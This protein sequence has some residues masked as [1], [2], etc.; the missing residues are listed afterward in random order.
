MIRSITAAEAIAQNRVQRSAEGATATDFIGGRGIVSQDA[1]AFLVYNPPHYVTPAHFH[2]VNQFQVVVQGTARIGTHR[3]LPGSVHYAETGTPY[4]PIVP[5]DEGLSYF[6]L[7]QTSPGGYFIMPGARNLMNR[8]TGRT[9]LA[10]ASID[11]P[12]RTGM[13][14][15]FGQPDGLAAYVLDAVGSAPLPQAAVDHGGAFCVVLAGEMLLDG[16]AYPE[17][18]C[19]SI[20]AGE[21]QPA[22][23]AGKSGA[24]VLFLSFPRLAA[25][26][27]H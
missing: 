21:A 6:T 19:I 22:M 15:L 16:R 1:L 20:G 12:S 23:I 14:E 27:T 2:D 5:D 17:R 24:V 18:S 10:D 11:L 9:F 13:K 8:K 7:R 26:I 25:P 4:G 3:V